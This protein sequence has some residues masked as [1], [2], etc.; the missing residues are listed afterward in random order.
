VRIIAT[1]E[2]NEDERVWASIRVN[3]DNGGDVPLSEVFSWD[4]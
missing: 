4:E 1:I 2:C 3:V